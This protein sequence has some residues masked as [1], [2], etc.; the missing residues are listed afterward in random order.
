MRR[1]SAPSL[2]GACNTSTSPMLVSS[3]MHTVSP[4]GL[5]AAVTPTTLMSRGSSDWKSRR[6]AE[7]VTARC[8]SPAITY[9]VCAIVYGC[10]RTTA[11]MMAG[12]LT[13]DGNFE[14]TSISG[15]SSLTLNITISNAETPL[16][17]VVLIGRANTGA[18]Q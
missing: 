15:P 16:P 8:A 18:G 6:P 4:R 3:K 12:R 9:S 11:D 5:T 13:G 17:E 14:T 7:S 1:N 2:V 10:V